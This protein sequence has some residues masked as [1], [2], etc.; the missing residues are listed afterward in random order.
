MVSD[1]SLSS[2]VGRALQAQAARLEHVGVVGDPQRGQRVLLD[3]QHGDALLADLLDRLEDDVDQHRRQAHGRLVEQQ[4][5][6]VAEQRA[7]DGEHLLLAAGHRARPSAAAVRAAPGTGRARSRGRPRS[8]ALSLRRNAP[9]SRFSDTVMRWKIRRPS[10]DWQMPALTT[11]WPAMPLIRAALEH[12]LAASRAQQPGDGAQ[13]RRLAGA[14]RPD[15]G[16][17]LAAVHL[18]VE[19]LDGGD[20][21]V[22]DRQLV[23]REQRFA[24]LRRG[25][26]LGGGL[27]RSLASSTV[28]WT[29]RCRTCR[30]RPR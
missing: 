26:T 14:V 6:R 18:E 1:S 17:D 22:A 8:A 11:S 20:V 3:Q 16:D 13:R 12:H 2:S 25:A 29:A 28:P 27:G 5:L 30:G 4:Q 24:V 21:A 7:R 10:G 19:V 9:R 23:Q 15:Q